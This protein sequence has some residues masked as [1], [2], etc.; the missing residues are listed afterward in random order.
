[1]KKWIAVL[2]FLVTGITITGVSFIDNIIISR[3]IACIVA[4]AFFIVGIFFKIGIIDSKSDGSNAFKGVFV[5]L[6]I[7]ALIIYLGIRRFQD[8]FLTSPMY[9]KII[10]P[11]VL[12]LLIIGV[13]GLIIY[14]HFINDEYVD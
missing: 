14:D 4:I 7:L 11:S 2:M 6:L 10:I 1:M 8:W 9:V 13:I 12:G 5:I 3:I